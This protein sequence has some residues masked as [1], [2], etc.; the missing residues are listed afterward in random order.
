MLRFSNF[1]YT[2][3]EEKAPP[4]GILHIDHPRE[5]AFGQVHHD[6]FGRKQFLHGPDVIKNTVGVLRGVLN[7]T[8][9]VQ[10]KGDD[11]VSFHTTVTP[12]GK[13]GVKYKGP[14]AQYN[15]SQRDIQR[16]YAEKPYLAKKLGA[17]LQHIGKVLPSQPGEYQGGFL[18]TPEDREVKGGKI[19]HT[20]NAITYGV[21]AKSEEGQKLANSRVSVMLHSMIDKSGATAPI[22]RNLQFKAHPD[23]HMMSP[24]ITPEEQNIPAE[25]KKVANR[26]IESINALLDGY[27]ASHLHGHEQTLRQYANRVIT[28]NEAPNTVGYINFLKEHHQKL[29]DGVK[30]EK[31]KKAKAAARDA[32]LAHVASKGKAF[33]KTFAIH[34]ALHNA[35]NAIADGLT[36]S[37]NRGYEHHVGETPASP[38]GFVARDNNGRVYKLV[39]PQIRNA[40]RA[41]SE[42]F[43]K[44]P[45]K[46]NE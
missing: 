9:E 15:F 6:E 28:N 18:S 25:N 2:I 38:E 10:E 11:A 5:N 44:K 23:V 3:T 7:R 40:L 30:T 34:N 46:E 39:P 1:Q 35:T 33:E 16:Q 21:D 22:P 45:N 14:G 13:V 31:A 26:H 20:P 19:R 8:T 36:Q 27:D 4:R 42:A 43:K 32:A 17:V 37:A 41:R 29:I 24:H 12:E